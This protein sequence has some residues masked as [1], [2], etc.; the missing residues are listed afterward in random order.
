MR[1]YQGYLTTL[2]IFMEAFQINKEKCLPYFYSYEKEIYE[3]FQQLGL[4]I[5]SIDDFINNWNSIFTKSTFILNI[6]EHSKKLLIQILLTIRINYQIREILKQDFFYGIVGKKKCG[7]STFIEQMLPG[8]NANANSIIN[9]AEMKPYKIADS[10]VMFDF[11]H[12][13]SNDV[14]HKLQFLFSRFLLDYVF[15]ICDAKERADSS[16]TTNFLQLV[17][18]SFDYRFT[19]LLNH[20][21]QFW[22]NIKNNVTKYATKEDLEKLRSDVCKKIEAKI[23]DD[24]VLLTCLNT[25]NMSENLIDKLNKTEIYTIRKLRNKVFERIVNQIPKSSDKQHIRDIILTKMNE[26]E[27]T[28]LK[29]KMISV[30]KLGKKQTLRLHLIYNIEPCKPEDEDH[31]DIKSFD[32]L[33]KELKDQFDM[34]NPVITENN[35]NEVGKSQIKRI[36]SF[37]DLLNNDMHNFLTFENI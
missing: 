16:D 4:F 15:F 8:A 11:P 13:E 19:V 2:E 26:K 29:Q 30:K 24:R 12:F 34:K 14:N 36:L 20:S 25:D 5:Y 32:E 1:Q 23:E 18:C 37:K 27:E 9:T 3:K 22:L 33:I 17:R 10:V 6:A 35:E 21:D 28:N 7:K 31:T